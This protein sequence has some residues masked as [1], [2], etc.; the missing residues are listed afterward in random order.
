MKIKMVSRDL[1]TNVRQMTET[2]NGY[3]EMN[4]IDMARA[5]AS[6]ILEFLRSVK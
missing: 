1:K 5:E 3:I 2:L 6:K 4:R